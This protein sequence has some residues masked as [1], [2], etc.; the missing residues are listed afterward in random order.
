MP[1]GLS[2][3]RRPTR[4]A[5][6]QFA[7]WGRNPVQTT[8]SNRPTLIFSRARPGSQPLAG[9]R[10]PSRQKCP[11]A[12]PA[13]SYFR[14]GSQRSRMPMLRTNARGLVGLIMI[15]PP[16]HEQRSS[17][18]NRSDDDSTL[19][20][21]LAQLAT[22]DVAPNDTPHDVPALS[23]TDLATPRFAGRNRMQS[24][25]RWATPH[26]I[27]ADLSSLKTDLDSALRK[28]RG[29]LRRTTSAAA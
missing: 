21:L 29:Q 24:S 15:D 28:V 18:R 16:S 4:T 13:P 6:W 1:S 25:V 20:G 19:S 2:S 12:Q 7:A 17:D 27:S 14:S 11:Q 26:E 22:S 23:G 5:P 8:R 9:C 10:G 3:L